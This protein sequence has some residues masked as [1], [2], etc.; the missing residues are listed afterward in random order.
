MRHLMSCLAAALLLLAQILASGGPLESAAGRQ[1]R[2]ARLAERRAGTI[3]IAHRGARTIAPENTLEAY[4]EAMNY[5]ADGCEVD[6]RRTADGVLVLFHDDMLDGVTDGFGKVEDLTYSELL[7][8][9]PEP[10]S[11]RQPRAHPS[12][13][14]ALFDLARQRAMLLV[15][16]V[17]QP[18]L[19]DQIT[20]MIEAADVWDHI[21]GVN[22]ETAPKLR[23]DARIRALRDKGG[24]YEDRQDFDPAAVK[25]ALNQP[26][27]ILVLEDP[28]LAAR[29][30]GRPP[31]IPLPLLTTLTT[32]TP[33]SPG[34]A[35]STN[36]LIPAD[37]L[38]RWQAHVDLRSTSNL[39][40]FVRQNPGEHPSAERILER[41]CAAS[42]L[43]QSAR[44]RP[45]LVLALVAMVRNPS[46]HDD[47]MYQ[48]LDAQAA[49][50]SLV[51]LRAVESAPA[52]IEAFNMVD[53][54]LMKRRDPL[55]K[56]PASWVDWRKKSLV[57]ALGQ[58]QCEAAKR[59]LQRY[60]AMSEAEARELSIPQF[61]EATRALLQ[62]QLDQ[63]ELADLLR[64]PNRS[65]RGR[66]ILE[67]LDHPT[68]ARTRALGNIAPWALDL[69]RA[70]A[71]N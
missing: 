29:Q 2:Q 11:R 9:G 61:E 30:L 60:V 32:E 8:L 22:A 70:R 50:R 71:G 6:V 13:L 69:P 37:Y 55:S 40:A 52:L 20:Q 19:D 53:P 62:Y 28:R 54:R 38:R 66:A 34:V 67:C 27:Q 43:G 42:R 44:K 56:Y 48:G 1:E 57:P 4:A 68:R 63:A 14:A 64:S 3:L 39:L 49:A 18:G 41:A 46:P 35:S 45:E 31:Y 47:W 24:V 21:V 65:V 36:N 26:G 7:A 5:G 23:A 51:Q 17:K 58:L 33:A 16:D 12:T 59:F 15:L 25:A 10:A